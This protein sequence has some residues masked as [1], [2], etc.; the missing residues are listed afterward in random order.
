MIPNGATDYKNKTYEERQISIYKNFND[1]LSYLNPNPYYRRTHS[2]TIKEVYDVVRNGGSVHGVEDIKDKVAY[3]QTHTKLEHE[4]IKKS[5][6][7]FTVSANFKDRRSIA[8]EKKYTQIIGFDF[9]KLTAEE[10]ARALDELKEWEASMLVFRSPSGKGIKL[11]VC[12]DSQEEQH[13]LIYRCFELYFKERFDLIADMQCIDCTR[14]CFFSHD[15]DAYYN[16][17]ARFVSTK[18][19]TDKYRHVISVNTTSYEGLDTIDYSIVNTSSIK[20]IF[21]GF[22][23]QLLLNNVSWTDGKRNRFLMEICKLKKWGVTFQECLAELMVFVDERFTNEYNAHTIPEKL[24]YNWQH[25]FKGFQLANSDKANHYQ[26]NDYLTEQKEFIKEELLAKRIIFVDAPTGAGKT[27]LI[28]QLANELNLKTDILMP[29]TAMV[30]QQF[31]IIGITGSKALSAE[32]VKANVLACCYNSISKIQDRS[33]KMLVI[34]EAHSLVSDYG[35]K[36]KTIQEIQRQLNRYEYIIYLSGSMLTLDGYY[37]SD[38]HLSFEK[39]NRFDYEYQIVELEDGVT[40]KDYF[41]SGIEQGKLNVFYQND[42]TVLDSLFTYLTGEGYAV[43]YISRDKKDRD[44]YK[45]IVE[46]SSLRGYDVLL[47]T[48]VIQ[49]GVNITDCD[50]EVVITFGRRTDLI[51]YIQ[52]TA[53]FRTNSPFVRI[54]HSNKMGA[55]RISD[56]SELLDRIEI[57]KQMLA[58]AR[59]KN[60]TRIIDFDFL[61]ADCIVKGYDL[62]FEDCDGN[63][64]TDSFRLLYENYQTL[65]HNT[66]SNVR[67]LKH[68]LSQFHFTEIN[69]G[70]VAV[71]EAK[72][73]KLKKVSRNNT[74]ELKERRD[75]VVNSILSGNHV[76][77]NATDNVTREVESRYYF[78]SKHFTDNDISQRVEL[79][80]SKAPFERYQ[81]RVTYFLAKADIKAGKQVSDK[82]LVEYRRL[83]HLEK[84]IKVNHT[85]TGVQL[86]QM[87]RVVGF[88]TSGRNYINNSLGI[89]YTFERSR[90]GSNYTITG[91]IQKSELITRTHSV[92]PVVEECLF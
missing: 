87:I 30:E 12:V 60:S 89:L 9:D 50:R 17:E 51:D 54:I 41:I 71:D 92:V 66:R 7:S 29:T 26:I 75:R 56:I 45:G 78:L 79:L 70:A 34:D 31:D 77:Y 16:G 42:K 13:V 48:C 49:A 85:Y 3:I 91:R 62:V 8:A 32:Q 22:V 69:K 81:Q 28:K 43:A 46:N 90:N 73:K 35:Y 86:K 2:F 19:L 39:K 80:K 74:K 76:F 27:T 1:G 25:Y 38:N 53:R 47:T 52:F 67:V 36:H 61:E 24:A 14:L 20:T 55:L 6:P 5:L 72:S 18:Q 37:S 11:F 33:S 63:Y 23:D 40:D 59:E 64:I 83:E 82:V 84:Q 68:Y 21:Y 88:D 4:F 10:T 65:C 58:K 44:E 57:E 15:P